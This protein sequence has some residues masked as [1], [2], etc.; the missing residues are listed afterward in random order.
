MTEV[1]THLAEVCTRLCAPA[2]YSGRELAVR[3]VVAESWSEHG[4]EP[5]QDA[6]GNLVARVGGAGERVLLTAHMDEVGF[7]VREITDDGFLLLG[8]SFGTLADAQAAR[9]PVGHPAAVMGRDRVVARASRPRSRSSA[10]LDGPSSTREA[11]PRCSR[12][13]CATRTR[14]SRWRTSATSRRRCRCSRPS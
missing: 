5:A 8:T 4:L 13:R 2:G 6:V 12:R 14:R 3:A 7:V 1:A 11:P 10:P 9:Y